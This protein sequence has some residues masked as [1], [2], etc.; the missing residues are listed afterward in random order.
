MLFHPTQ[1]FTKN[2]LQIEFRPA[3]VSDSAALLETLYQ[4]A[5][6]STY[7]L[8]TPGS[9]R[10]KSIEDE[11]KWI[12]DN[13]DHPKCILVLATH[14]NQIVGICSFI[15]W[16]DPRREHRGSFGISILKKYQNQGIGQALLR[17]L[18]EQVRLMPGVQSIELSVM[19]PNLGA[20][21]IYESFGFVLTGRTPN[22]FCLKDGSYADDLSMQ[23]WIGGNR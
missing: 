8:S 16:K 2:G 17:F 5:T 22:A 13:N 19:S 21:H 4:I 14:L 7:I 11:N 23:L 12:Q 18:I 3:Q 1:V 9:V 20:I 10:K 6:E 15:A